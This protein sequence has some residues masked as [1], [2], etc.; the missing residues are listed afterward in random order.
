MSELTS[1]KLGAD[2]VLRLLPHRR[3]FVFLDGIRGLTRQPRPTLTGFK[4]VSVNEPVF[5]GHFPGLSLWPGVYTIEGLGQ[6]VNALLVLLAIVE[7]FERHEHTEAEAFEALRAID[8]RHRLGAR[9]ATET[10]RELIERLG[11]ASARVGLAGAIDVK[12]I[13]PVFAGAT[14][15]YRVTLTHAFSN[16][17]RF[18]VL[19]TV[20]GR[21]VA[22]G[23]MSSALP[24]AFPT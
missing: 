11:P 19:A 6:A 8:A 24:H 23:T 22:E 3:P 2:T 9:P 1:L 5:E 10:E 17:R 12:L 18:D 16:A 4:Q 15:E 21:P 13:E 7:G 14:L 20:D